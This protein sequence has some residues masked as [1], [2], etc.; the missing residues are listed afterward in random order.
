MYR[1]TYVYTIA[2]FLYPK[3]FIHKLSTHQPMH[4]LFFIY[5]DICMFMCLCVCVCVCVRVH[6]CTHVC[7]SIPILNKY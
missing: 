6:E 3:N 5:T 7:V 1:N 2:K 4:I